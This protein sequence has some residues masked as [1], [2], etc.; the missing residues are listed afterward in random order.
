MKRKTRTRAKRATEPSGRWHLMNWNEQILIFGSK[1][2]MMLLN[3][4]HFDHM[5]IA[6][7]SN[8]WNNKSNCRA[9]H[10]M[11]VLVHPFRAT[12][13][14]WWLFDQPLRWFQV[15]LSMP[16]F[17]SDFTSIAAAKHFNEMTAAF[18]FNKP[19]HLPMMLCW[20]QL[21][22]SHSNR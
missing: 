7:I 15:H 5:P 14:K 18:E 11:T 16:L 1:F 13:S 3:E 6:Y 19:D 17:G 4:H 10:I 8:Q 20:K 22:R 12:H 9:F 21:S 2:Q